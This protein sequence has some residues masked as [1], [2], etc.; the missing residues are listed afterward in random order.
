MDS[1]PEIAGLDQ[2]QGLRQLGGRVELF[3]R[4]LRRFAEQ[5]RAAL[6]DLEQLLIRGERTAARRA[7]HSLK[8]A[9]ASLGAVELTRL[10][11]T[12]EAALDSQRDADEIADAGRTV[13]VSLSGLVNAIASAL[14]PGP[15]S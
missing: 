1:V 15:L 9:A 4:L 8:G 3:V 12:F 13:V 5:Y 7:A 14:P 10:L 6:P 11:E 2:A